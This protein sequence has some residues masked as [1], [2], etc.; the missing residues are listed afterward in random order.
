MTLSTADYRIKKQVLAMNRR[1]LDSLT[2]TEEAVLKHAKAYGRKFGLSIM[3]V[4]DLT[5]P[6][7]VDAPKV[8]YVKACSG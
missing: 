6:A 7:G 3:V 4:D 2:P 8:V 1:Y 5:A